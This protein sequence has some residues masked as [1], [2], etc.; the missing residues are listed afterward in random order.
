M[1]WVQIVDR[2]MNQDFQGHAEQCSYTFSVGPEQIPGMKQLA[3]QIIDSHVKKLQEENSKLL[4][5]RVW[6]D[7]SPTWTS[8]YYVE[9]V[10]SASPLFWNLIIGGVLAILFVIAIYFTIKE[11]K[12]ITQYIGE[13]VSPVTTN[14]A[15]VL[16]IGVVAIVGIVLWR[17]I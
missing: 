3:Q 4:E 5:L 13:N 15:L 6:E 7:T 14:I 17:R 9:V 8:D 1:S 11:I 2:K 16:G 10:A 12:N